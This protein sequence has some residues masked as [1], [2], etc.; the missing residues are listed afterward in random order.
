[1][2]RFGIGWNYQWVGSLASGGGRRWQ[3]ERSMSE[4][5][6]QSRTLRLREEERGFALSKRKKSRGLRKTH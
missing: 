3:K 5:E 6:E 4:A 1:M 2:A